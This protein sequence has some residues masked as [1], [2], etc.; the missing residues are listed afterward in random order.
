MDEVQW[1]GR[2]SAKTP[3][4][5][6]IYKP[7]DKPEEEV[8]VESTAKREVSGKAFFSE[9]GVPSLLELNETTQTLR[10]FRSAKGVGGREV[11]APTE[12]KSIVRLRR[13]GD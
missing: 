9:E 11:K 10:T 8:L 3:P 13:R 4:Y 5:S 1:G 12:S 6:W 7:K 2:S